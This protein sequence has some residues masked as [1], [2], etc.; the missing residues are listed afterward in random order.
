MNI[1]F[2]TCLL[3]EA[4]GLVHAV[5]F[6]CVTVRKMVYKC[7][8]QKTR[9]SYS[10]QGF[11]KLAVL[12]QLTPNLDPEDVAGGVMRVTD[13]ML[14]TAKQAEIDIEVEVELIKKQNDERDRW[15]AMDDHVGDHLESLIEK[16]GNNSSRDLFYIY[17]DNKYMSPSQ[18]GEKFEN[19]GL[20]PPHFLLPP[21]NI[22]HIPPH[23]VVMTLL[24]MYT[25][26]CG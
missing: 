14:T 11:D 3:V 7:V 12:S 19:A 4:T 23:I 20:C 5:W 22:A 26:K 15:N 24:K 10:E 6:L 16:V 2:R 9:K 17:G 21:D 18:C 8:C 13:E 1:A 25:E